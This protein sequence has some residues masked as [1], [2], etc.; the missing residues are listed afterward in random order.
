MLH[1]RIIVLDLVRSGHD[2]GMSPVGRRVAA[3]D[4]RPNMRLRMRDRVRRRRLEP[5]VEDAHFVPTAGGAISTGG[6]RHRRHLGQTA[7]AGVPAELTRCV[8]ERLEPLGPAPSCE[9][10]PGAWR[11]SSPNTSSQG[12]LESSV[13]LDVAE[14]CRSNVHARIAECG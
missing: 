12:A 2:E 5:K 8:A 4:R 13:S 9:N 14:F 3:F 10:R 1:H 7:Y 6:V 11:K